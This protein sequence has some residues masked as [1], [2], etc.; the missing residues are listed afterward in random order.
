M[1]A[2]R[3]RLAVA[4]ALHAGAVASAFGH[5]PAARADE[6]TTGT[7]LHGAARNAVQV[8]DATRSSA[9]D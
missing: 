9:P 4:L 1:H 3:L 8:T 6:P 7:R 2:D 5:E